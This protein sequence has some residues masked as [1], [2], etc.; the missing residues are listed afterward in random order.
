[1]AQE[2]A[3]VR[4]GMQQGMI[5]AVDILSI[6]RKIFQPLFSF[7]ISCCR[8]QNTTRELDRIGFE[9]FVLRQTEGAANASAGLRVSC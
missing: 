7:E 6:L 5:V 4:L 1:M 3:A 9:L 8:R 2:S